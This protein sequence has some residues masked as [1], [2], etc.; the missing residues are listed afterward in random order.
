MITMFLAAALAATAPAITLDWSVALGENS[1]GGPVAFG[2]PQS[3]QGV[4]VTLGS[5]RVLLIGPDGKIRTSMKLDMPV[6]CPA[7]SGKMTAAGE[8]ILAADLWGS[9][10]C[11]DITGRR[12]WKYARAS[13]TGGG[14]NYIVLADLHG[15]GHP[16]AILT[17]ARGNLYAVDARGRLRLEVHVTDFRVS[18]PAV[19]DVNGD[20]RPELVFGS[21]DSEIYCLDSR[22]EVLWTRRLEGGRFGR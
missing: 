5:G 2:S 13:R 7:A 4:L 10:Y 3:A 21:E 8:N 18:A 11:F 6:A 20:G 17:D 9:L 14:F 1:A 22:G 15:D 12:L 16:E 19:G